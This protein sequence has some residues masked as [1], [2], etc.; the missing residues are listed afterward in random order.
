[1][2]PTKRINN[3]SETTQMYVIREDTNNPD[4]AFV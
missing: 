1:M 3:P 4:E 2:L